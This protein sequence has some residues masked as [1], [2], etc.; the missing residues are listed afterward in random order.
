[1]VE[2]YYSKWKYIVLTLNTMF[3]NDIAETIT[4]VGI[5]V[6]TSK[7]NF[8]IFT[9]PST[10]PVGSSPPFEMLAPENQCPSSGLSLQSASEFIVLVVSQ[11]S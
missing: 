7:E 1:M 10:M 4:A 3:P 8:I 9:R 11:I 5:R 6:K 2:Y